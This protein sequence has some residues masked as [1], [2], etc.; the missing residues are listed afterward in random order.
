MARSQSGNMVAVTRGTVLPNLGTFLIV[1]AMFIVVK[2]VN[3]AKRKKEEEVAP[4]K[5]PEISVQE[6]LLTEIRDL[7]KERA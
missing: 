4:G 2:L 1:L 7:L 6:K 3:K 5:P